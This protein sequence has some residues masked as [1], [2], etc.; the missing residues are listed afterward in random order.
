MSPSLMALFGDLEVRVPMAGL[1]DIAAELSRL[2]KEIDKVQA[3]LVR[4]EGKLTNS[5]F[6]ERAPADIVAAE[7]QKLEQAETSLRVLRQQRQKIEELR[8]D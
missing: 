8:S 2:D 6:I 3:D 7:R 4:L 1:V 5:N